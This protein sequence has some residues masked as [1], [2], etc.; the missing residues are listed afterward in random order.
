[1]YLPHVCSSI[2]PPRDLYGLPLRV[3]AVMV[4]C[5]TDAM[6]VVAMVAAV[7]VPA[8]EGADDGT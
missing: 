8:D 4:V 2:H 1:M 5:Y 3:C 7:V 6:E